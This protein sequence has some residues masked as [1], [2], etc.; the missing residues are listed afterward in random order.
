MYVIVSTLVIQSPSDVVAC[1]SGMAQFSCAFRFTSGTPSGAM[2]FRNGNIDVSSASFH[3]ITDNSSGDSLT[4]AVISTML[5]IS[6]VTRAG[7]ES[8]VNYLCDEGGVR[9]DS[10]TLTIIS[11]IFE[12]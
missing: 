3:V 1:S 8:G 6:N 10:A 4:P 2:W 7:I 9:T 5:L 11:G 12:Q